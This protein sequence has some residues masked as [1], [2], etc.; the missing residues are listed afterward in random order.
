MANGTECC[1]P[2]STRAQRPLL[3]EAVDTV[4]EVASYL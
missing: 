1:W 4:E 3:D 2:V